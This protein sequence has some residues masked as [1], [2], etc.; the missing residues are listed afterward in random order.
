VLELI[1]GRPKGRRLEVLCVGAHCDDIE[2]GCGGSLLSLQQRYPSCRLHWLVLTSGSKRRKEALAAVEAF[3]AKPARGLTRILDLPDGL[4]PAHFAKVK[5]SFEELKSEMDPDL[6]FTHHADDRHQ[7]HGL[8][9]QV[10]WQ[11]FRDHLIWEYEIPKYDG[12][13]AT[14]NFYVPLALPLA[15][16]KVALIMDAFESQRGKPWF[17]SENLEAMMRIRGLECRAMSGFAEA[18]HCRKAVCG[19]SGDEPERRAPAR[20]PKK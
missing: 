15:R 17:R 19:F 4:L 14:P 2:I 18:F 10:T 16:R 9:S 20:R 13:L 7:D 12:D 1:L 5:A 8:V 11:T 6:V 3:V